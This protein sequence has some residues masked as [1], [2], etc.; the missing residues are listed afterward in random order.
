MEK[1]KAAGTFTNDELEDMLPLRSA[2]RGDSVVFEDQN[3]SSAASSARTKITSLVLLSSIGVLSAITAFAVDFAVKTLTRLRTSAAFG[4]DNFFLS[5]AIWVCWFVLLSVAATLLCK[6]I[7]DNALG[8]GLPQMKSILSG[9][10]IH[11]Y[12][13]LRT[14][15]SKVL[16]LIVA[17][18]AGLSIGKE[19]PF[20]HISSCIAHSLVTHVGLFKQF[21]RDQTIYFSILGA[22]VAVGVVST[23]G[24]PVGGVMFS[25]E[26]TATYYMVSSLQ[27]AMIAAVA[28]CA[29]FKMIHQWKLYGG[30]SP[31][32]L[33]PPTHTP[34]VRLNSRSPLTVTLS[35][36][37]GGLVLDL[38]E[39][40]NFAAIQVL[41]ILPTIAIILPILPTL[42]PIQAPVAQPRRPACPFDL[43]CCLPIDLH[44]CTL[45]T[46]S[47]QPLGVALTTLH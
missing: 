25:I 29:T 24:A 27:A 32:H 31:S 14:C 43:H 1:K 19:G 23:F 2:G 12:L 21:R 11:K 39:P 20:V 13:S 17:T 35:A 34:R 22:A 38:F 47:K 4:V 7:D 30:E 46:P 5:Y 28:G 3:D 45:A 18:G 36:G 37:G 26:V 9:F 41:P 8:S 40:T 6:L 16:G 10:V 15:A 44:C 42:Q 33:P